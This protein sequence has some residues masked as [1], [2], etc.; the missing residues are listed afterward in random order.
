MVI[1]VAEVEVYFP[2]LGNHT[3]VTCRRETL[4]SIGAMILSGGDRR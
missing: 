3:I 4:G 2:R 1:N